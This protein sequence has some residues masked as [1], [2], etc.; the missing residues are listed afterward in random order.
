[1]IGL[2]FVSHN[3]CFLQ[4]PLALRLEVP[5]SKKGFVDLQLE[6]IKRNISWS[7]NYLSLYDK[8]KKT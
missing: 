6:A 7:I 1:M 3:T 5:M 2:D 4:M 8:Q